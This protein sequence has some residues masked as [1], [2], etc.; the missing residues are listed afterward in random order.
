MILNRHDF[1]FQY[2]DTLLSSFVNRKLNRKRKNLSCYG[3]S[4]Y[5]DGGH[6][7]NPHHPSGVYIYYMDPEPPTDTTNKSTLRQRRYK[8]KHR[9][10]INKKQRAYRQQTQDKLKIYRATKYLT[11]RIWIEEY[12][13]Q[14]PCVRCGFADYRALQFHHRDQKQKLFGISQKIGKIS[15]KRIKEE[16]DKCY[17]LCANCHQIEHY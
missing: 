5:V 11:H 14:H 6:P 15:L 7:R 12:K 9:S 16:I 4:N 17:V 3:Y 8:T 2:K 10:S 13:K 1:P